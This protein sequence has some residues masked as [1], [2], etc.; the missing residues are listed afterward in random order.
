MSF[1]SGFEKIAWKKELLTSI[2]LMAAPTAMAG[3]EATAPSI[4]HI[5]HT[6]AQ[7]YG[8]DPKI[9]KGLV[10]RE[11]SFRPTAIN[12]EGKKDI[13]RQSLGLAQVRPSTAKWMG[14]KGT[15]Q[16]LLKPEVNLEY[17]AKYLARNLKRY[18]GDYNK[19]LSAYNAGR[20]TTANTKYVKDILRYARKIKK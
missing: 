19:A 10:F 6:K 11:S 14:H 20:Y 4:D 18:Q 1:N 3:Q 7:K 9:L 15:P 8:I 2:A 17:S 5:I 12:T 13:M 16:D